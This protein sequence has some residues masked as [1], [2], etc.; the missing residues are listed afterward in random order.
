MFRFKA[1]TLVLFMSTAWIAQCAQANEVELEKIVVTP[2]RFAEEAQKAPL[3]MNIITR[4]EIEESLA[5]N[6]PDV[7]NSQAGIVVRDYYGNATKVTV[8]LR[9]FGETAGSNVLVLIDGRRVNEIDLSG[10]DWT[11]IPLDRIE[12]IEVMRG[13]GSVLYGD[14]AAAG[15]I[16]LITK[17]GKGRPKFQLQTSAGSFKALKERFTME[18]SEDK[19]SYFIG[20]TYEET[21]G[22]RKNSYYRGNDISARLLYDYSASS[23][24][25]L[26]LGY[27]NSDY[28]LPGAL[29]ES[30]L[31]TNSRRN[32]LFVNDDAGE[33]DW[34]LDLEINSKIIDDLKFNSHISFRRRRLDNNLI[35]SLAVDGRRIDTLSFTPSLTLDKKIF[36]TPNRLTLGADFYRYD[37][38]IDA[39]SY[40]GLSFY[41]GSITRETDID[42][43]IQGYY[44]QNQSTLTDSLI[45][46][47]G[48]RYERAKYTFDS[49]PLSGPWTADPFWLGT[50]VDE[51]LSVN[52][53][54]LDLGL[55]YALTENSNLFARFTRG[56]RFPA[57]DEYYSL[58]A[59]PPVNINLLAQVCKTY[60]L[61]INHKFN[62]SLSTKVNIFEMRIDNELYYD[63]LTYE[64][65][66]YDKTKH[67]GLEC[68]FKWQP[69]ANFGFEA[70][71]TYTRAFFN[72][73]TYN[74]NQIPLVPYHKGM[75]GIT[76]KIN[77][78][79]QIKT[80]VNYLGERYFISDQAHQYPK[81]KDAI[82]T[83]LKFSYKL[84]G[85]ELFLSLNN[86]FDIDYSEF[87]AISTVYGER[88]YYPSPGF[89]LTL[90]TTVNF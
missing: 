35:S 30:Q 83:D 39:Y 20:C 75:A 19:I 18:G 49:Y 53:Q 2:Y 78:A 57:T 80:L 63:P 88:G 12:R 7:L 37:S 50:S 56:F 32:S 70:N 61:G 34:Y 28:G 73:G 67:R 27:H 44:L 25:G 17:R 86:I 31:L 21:D 3:A 14:N 85:L 15:V 89:N 64:N 23:F 87:G 74:R 52:E 48:Y 60:E 84:K 54:A 45:F 59:S 22:F 33:E 46:N 26:S 47:L 71:Y 36:D 42:K 11:Q 82:I 38:L 8:D 40:A 29:R 65:K 55:S 10:V 76:F 41:Q 16:N 90:G 6:I 77:E 62:P 24:L 69:F 68:E 58:W 9:G 13:A 81:M 4:Q 51:Q 79:L 72:G 5:A 66:N 43:E 1:A